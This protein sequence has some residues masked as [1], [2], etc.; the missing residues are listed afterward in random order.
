MEPG[1]SI[2]MNKKHAPVKNATDNGGTPAGAE[3]RKICK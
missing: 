2:G 1:I 3:E